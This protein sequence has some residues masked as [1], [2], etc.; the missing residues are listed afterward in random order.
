MKIIKHTLLVIAAFVA[1]VTIGISGTVR[2]EIAG[3]P[4]E[5]IEYS[6]FLILSLVYLQ[7]SLHRFLTPLDLLPKPMR[8]HILSKSKHNYK[9]GF[10]KGTIGAGYFLAALY[11]FPWIV[12]AKYGDDTP[13]S[14]IGA[15]FLIVLGTMAHSRTLVKT[16]AVEV[17]NQDRNPNQGTHSI[18]GSAGSE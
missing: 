18:T 1:W 9:A 5:I 12:N 7:W 14:V 13:N 6:I 16:L 17:I 8:Q 11:I 2:S 3:Q 15:V 10:F 4:K